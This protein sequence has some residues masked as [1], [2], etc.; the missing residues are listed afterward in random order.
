[1]VAGRLAV[2]SVECRHASFAGGLPV[3]LNIAAA[4]GH[5][6]GSSVHPGFHRHSHPQASHRI[7]NRFS[8]PRDDPR[9]SC[10]H[11]GR[12]ADATDFNLFKRP[13]FPCLNQ[14][15]DLPAIGRDRHLRSSGEK[16]AEP[17][18]LFR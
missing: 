5:R 14:Y 2:K 10:S 7:T 1:M 15:I 9:D 18:K 13:P 6:Q 8:I 4:C 12:L 3:R 16:T 11:D 17:G